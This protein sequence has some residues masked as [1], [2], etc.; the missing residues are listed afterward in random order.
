MA[1]IKIPVELAERFYAARSITGDYSRK[2]EKKRLMAEV[3]NLFPAISKRIKLRI[4]VEN[5]NNPLYCV[6]RD[7]H[8]HVPFDDGQPE[9]MALAPKV[10]T[11]T[12]VNPKKAVAKK[13]P[14][15]VAAKKPAPKPVAAKKAPAK[16]KA[17][18]AKLTKSKPSP[19]AAA[20]TKTAAKL[21]VAVKPQ[22]KAKAS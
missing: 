10:S 19:V 13:A 2:Q 14:A 21:V 3:H 8:S 22:P 11:A 4:A 20:K 6:I 5:P 17:A 12:D 1:Q 9:P 16:P 15:K 18:P 7:K